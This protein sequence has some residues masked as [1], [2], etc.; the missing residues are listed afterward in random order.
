MIENIKSEHK[1]LLANIAEVMK[2]AE[3]PDLRAVICEFMKLAGGA[4]GVAKM[5]RSEYRKAKSGSMVRS[6]ILQMILQGAKAVAMK[7]NQSDTSLMNETDL[8]RMIE[9]KMQK[10]INA[11]TPGPTTEG[12][13]G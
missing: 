7:E 6:M 5:L 11:R 13:P 2:D 4:A 12:N 9:S 10:A 1:E 8:D 3:F